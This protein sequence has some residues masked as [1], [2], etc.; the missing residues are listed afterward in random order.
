MRR[1]TAS[2][3]TRQGGLD[4]KNPVA[5]VNRRRTVFAG[6]LPNGQKRWTRL[7]QCLVWS[8]GSGWRGCLRRGRQGDRGHGPRNCLD[9]AGPLRG[10]SHLAG[11]PT[12]GSH[13]GDGHGTRRGGRGAKHAGEGRLRGHKADKQDR[14][15]LEEP[16]HA[17]IEFRRNS[18]GRCAGLAQTARQP[19]LPSGRVEPRLWH[20]CYTVRFDFDVRKSHL[21]RENPRRGIGFERAQEIFVHPYYQDRRSE[22]PE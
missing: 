22:I 9:S 10:D 16:F 8:I 14:D 19:V 5:N 6:G 3:R 1:G 18:V 17:L 4:P 2:G 20:N 12:A 21:L 15:G 13:V 7:G 11:Q